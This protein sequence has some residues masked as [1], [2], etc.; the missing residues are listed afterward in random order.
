[1]KRFK[2]IVFLLILG[3]SVIQGQEKFPNSLPKI[4]ISQIQKSTGNIETG[5]KYD[6]FIDSIINQTNLDS[7]IA[8]VRI[9]SGEDSVWINGVKIRIQSRRGDSLKYLA[10]DYIENQLERYNLKVYDQIYWVRVLNSYT[11]FT[12]GRN[13]YAIQPGYLYPEKQFIICA[14]YDAKSNYSA[15]DNASGV[16]AVLEAARIFSKYAFKY[17]VVYALWDQEEEGL[18]GSR[19][20]VGKMQSAQSD[21]LGVLNIDMIGWDGDSDNLADIHT[22]DIANSDSLANQIININTLYN[23]SLNPVIYNPGSSNSDHDVFWS[24]G[25]SAIWLIEAYYGNEFNDFNPYYHSS[26]DRIDKFNLPYFHKLSKLAIGAISTLSE[27]TSDTIIVVVGSNKVYRTL[28]K[29]VAINGANTNFLDSKETLK[30]WLTNGTDTIMADSLVVKSN[31]FLTAYFNIPKEASIGLWDINV[32]TENKDTLTQRNGIEILP[33]PAVINVSPYT[34]NISVK[35]GSTAIDN[36]ILKNTGASELSF[37]SPNFDQN[38]ALQFDGIDDYLEINTGSTLKDLG[39]FTLS[40]W[41]YPTIIP[42]NRSSIIRK[43]FSYNMFLDGGR[44]SAETFKQDFRLYRNIYEKGNILIKP[45]EWSF[46]T[47]VWNGTDFILYVN[48]VSDSAFCSSKLTTL[49]LKPLWI[50]RSSEFNEP[51]QG[52]IDEI[53]IWNVVRSQQEVQNDMYRSLT[54]SEHG[55]IGYW[56]FNEATGDSIY[57]LSTND[58][59]GI[60]NSGVTWVTYGALSFAW[61]SIESD[62]RTCESGSSV[63]IKVKFDASKLNPGEY[64]ATLTLLSNDP[65]NPIVKIPVK[66]SVTG[67]TDIEQNTEEL[68]LFKI[69]PNP[70]NSK[71]VISY[72]LPVFGDVELSVYDLN[73]RK[74]TTLVKDQQQAGSYEFEW[75][76]EGI[77]PGVYICQLKTLQ[78]L[79]VMKI[80]VLK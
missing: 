28:I 44:L 75:N 72:C 46:V 53:S 80:T 6:P 43:D 62:T 10:A 38:Y 68:T 70:F 5:I 50:G 18:I 24:A 61:I 34:L 65:I 14:H 32:Q 47:C 25:Y 36:L 51:F 39:K 35:S 22:K 17:T 48:G 55:L 54:G 33:E 45:N 21:I 3:L 1:M 71:T 57:D 2:I 67:T 7:L 8:T 66:M 12:S 56:N 40:A 74:V 15:D 9:L 79:Q 31:S 27:I 16:A 13:I 59:N 73:G 37:N 29:E 49:K 78:R 60:L 63:E 52:I 64:S 23:L 11:D 4:D 58:N 77:K 19:Y 20:Y 42:S 69:Y 76:A 41:I 30:I 26:N